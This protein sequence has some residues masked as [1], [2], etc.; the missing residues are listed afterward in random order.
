MNTLNI[1]SAITGCIIG[2]ILGYIIAYIQVKHENKLKRQK[3]HT[4]KG[5]K[6]L[7]SEKPRNEETKKNT[8]KP[9]FKVGDKIY[10]KTHPNEYWE[11]EE[12]DEKKGEYYIRYIFA[13]NGLG[14]ED[15]KNWECIEK[16]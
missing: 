13:V 10:R 12:V 11:V 8:V 5:L 15:Q 14:F 3:F 6:T 4:D 9:I 7:T 2:S 16:S 1:L